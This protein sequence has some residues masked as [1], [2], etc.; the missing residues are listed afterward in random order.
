MRYKYTDEMVKFMAAGF[1]KW[2]IPEL[3]E[4]FNKKFGTDK[5]PSQIKAAMSN[6]KIRCGRKT[7][8]ITRGEYRIFTKEQA[9]F[10]KRGYKKWTI[11]RVTEEFNK[12]FGDNKTVSQIRGF[13]RNHGILSG[14]TGCFEK[15]LIPHNKGVKGWQPGGR[16]QEGR[17]K[18]GNVPM[19]HRPVGSERVDSKGGFIMIKVAEPRKWRAKHVVEW[20][21]H[22]G[23][24]PK[25]HC[26]TF[27]D[28]NPLNWQVDNL[29]LATRAQMAVM[30]RFKLYLAPAELKDAAKTCAELIMKTGKLRREA[31]A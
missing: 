19:Q 4:R 9:E 22:N 24:V 18:K 10:I 15:G 8:E 14:R 29:M 25:G 23:P 21:K 3:T 12:R 1:K 16:A 7:N 11:E 20:E 2:G 28:N 17:F 30:N 6:R 31:N 26:V 5:K 13:T 27:K